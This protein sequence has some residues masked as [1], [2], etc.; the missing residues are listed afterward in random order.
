MPKSPTL[1]LKIIKVNQHLRDMKYAIKFAIVMI[2][3][4]S[5]A[6]LLYTYHLIDSLT[7]NLVTVGAVL[8]LMVFVGKKWFK[9]EI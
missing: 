7:A 1:F 9:G 4:I 6:Q 5:I 3:M 8:F 2:L